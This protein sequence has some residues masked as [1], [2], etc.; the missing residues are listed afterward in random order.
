MAF[1]VFQSGSTL[2]GLDPN[3]LQVALTL[4]TGVTI[5]PTLKPR[6]AVM[7]NYAIIVNSPAR[8]ITVDANLNVRLLTPNPPVTKTTVAAGNTGTLSGDYRVRQTYIVFDSF[9]AIVSESDFGPTSSV[10]TLTSDM[11]R[12]SGINLS[13]DQVSATRLYRTTTGTAVYFKWID[14]DGNTQT[15]IE[16]DL[17]DAGLATFSAPSLGSPPDLAIIAEFKSRLYGIP[18]T[19]PNNIHY[20]EIGAQ[21]AWPSDNFQPIPRLGSDPRGGTGLIRRRDALGIGRV[22]GFYQL[23]GT[24]DTN[25]RITNVSENCGIEAT[26]SPAVFRDTA[27]FLW[28]DGVYQWDANGLKSV[29]DG[30]V[31]SWFTN[32]DT[33]NPSRFQHAFA[34]ID[35]LRYKYRLYLASAGSGIENCWIEYDFM[36]QKWW[37]PHFSQAMNPT[38]VFL[39]STN[40]GSVISIV[41][42]SDGWL[43]ADRKLRTDDTNIAIPMDVVTVQNDAGAP[44][45]EKY[46]GSVSVSTSKE[47]S[48]TLTVQSVVGDFDTTPTKATL[49]EPMEHDLK[50]TRSNLDRVGIG[51]A[52]KLRFKNNEPGVDAKLRGFEID[53]V[54]TVGKR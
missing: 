9:G 23:S 4:P 34:T 48:G 11:L 30:K 37:G 8:P 50:E 32:N 36:D 21:Y 35:P 16:D 31:R 41:G 18:K 46:F 47:P 49:S 40:T 26:D 42:G 33:F 29:S 38:S 20:S 19:N 43:R 10:A 52:F 6:F 27:F 1:S 13:L 7:G 12:V 39:M 14:L 28:K 25:I 17:S 51:K 44:D 2:Y 3:G 5:D 45:D 15:T 24:S 53:Q 22:N 54:F